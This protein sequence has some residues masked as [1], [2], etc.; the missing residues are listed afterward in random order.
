MRF[1]REHEYKL[2]K[3]EERLYKEVVYD[4]RVEVDNDE[5]IVYSNPL[6]KAKAPSRIRN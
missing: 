2:E 1:R 4:M 6:K 3:H 5:Q